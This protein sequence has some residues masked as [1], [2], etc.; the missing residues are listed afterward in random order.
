[1]AGV[2]AQTV[3]LLTVTVGLGFIV[4]TPEALVLLQFVVVS[5]IT[6]E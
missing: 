5:V 2:P 4:I 6:T 3:G 1:V